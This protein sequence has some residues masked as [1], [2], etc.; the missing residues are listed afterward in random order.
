MSPLYVYLLVFVVLL[1]P[2]S[3]HTYINY[4]NYKTIWGPQRRLE[5]HRTTRM[6]PIIEP[7]QNYTLLV[8]C[9]STG[10]IKASLPRRWEHGRD[11]GRPHAPERGRRGKYS[12]Q[13]GSR[14]GLD[15]TC[16]ERNCAPALALVAEGAERQPR[17]PPEDRGAHQS[18][19]RARVSE[20]LG[21]PGEALEEQRRENLAGGEQGDP[22]PRRYPA[23]TRAIIRPGCPGERRRRP[24]GPITIATPEQASR[25]YHEIMRGDVD[26]ASVT[27]ALPPPEARAEPHGDVFDV[28][29]EQSATPVRAAPERS[30]DTDEARSGQIPSRMPSTTC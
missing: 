20:G 4:I 7:E 25:I 9:S 10:T 16:G 21:P 18:E 5:L 11:E 30:G 12:G 17:R 8:Q 27:F 22:R 15:R 13:R 23:Q 19:G 29:P 26:P 2:V 24:G 14:R 3:I 6:T 1:V 28:Q